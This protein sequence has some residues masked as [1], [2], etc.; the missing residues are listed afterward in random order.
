MKTL[1]Q[2]EMEFMSEEERG[3]NILG[4]PHPDIE[5]AWENLLMV[6]KNELLWGHV[7]LSM[8]T[9]TDKREFETY[10][11]QRER[12]THVGIIPC[13]WEYENDCDH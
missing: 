7:D 11:E 8:F 1:Y 10:V 4:A 2:F 9:H 12:T 5:Q 13:T 6:T 3:F